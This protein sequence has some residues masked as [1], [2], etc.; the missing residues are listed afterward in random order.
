MKPRGTC[1][2]STAMRLTAAGRL[3]TACGVYSLRLEL[4]EPSMLTAQG[5]S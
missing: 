4:L 5:Y 3:L 2:C 1:L